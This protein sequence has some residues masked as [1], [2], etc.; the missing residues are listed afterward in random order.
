VIVATL[1]V[2]SVFMLSA[3]KRRLAGHA[4]TP[5]PVDVHTSDVSR[6][7]DIG[8]DVYHPHRIRLAG[9]PRS[10]RMDLKA[11]QTAGIT[12]GMLEYHSPLRVVTAP[13]HDS[14][15]VNF[16]LFGGI[17]MG[18]GASEV[19]ISPRQAAVHGWAEQTTMSGWARP[20]RVLGIKIPRTMVEQELSLLLGRPATGPVTFRGDLHLSGPAGRDWVG[21]VQ[22]LARTLGPG[23][24]LTDHPL[25]AAP[26]AQ[27]VVRGLLLAAPHNH[28][29]ALTGPLEPAGPGH[30]DEA[31]DFLRAQ[32][33]RPLTVE[34]IAASVGV[35]VRTLQAA[36]RSQVGYSPMTALR[37][38]RLEYARRDLERATS[39]TTVASVAGAWGFSHPGR[40]SVHY[41]QAFGESPSETLRRYGAV[42]PA[43]LLAGAPAAR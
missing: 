11:T 10:F 3:W 22:L 14:Y 4:E 28:S 36:F 7:Q 1:W 24:S 30:V 29:E 33:H 41:A 39:G 32:A 42:I 2:E 19:A 12:V 6:A 16:T 23:P 43:R 40:F 21:A 17:S 38:V 37:T 25:I 13:L 27:A 26:A 18:Y 31:M 20:A 15:Q 9:S 5:P 34:D 8:G 35:S